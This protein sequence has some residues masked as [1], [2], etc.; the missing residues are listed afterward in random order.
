MVAISS[1]LQPASRSLRKPRSKASPIAGASASSEV[2]RKRVVMLVLVVYVLAIVEGSIRKW[3]LPQFSQ[4]IY[5]IRDP[6]LILAY[7]IATQHGLWPRNS[8]LF[9]VVVAMCGLGFVLVILQSA[10]GGASDTRF[11]LSVHGYRSYF[12][13][14]PLAFLVGAQFQRPDL[15]RFYRLTLWLAIPIAVLVFFQFFSPQGAAINVGSSSDENL[16]FR[17]LSTT[18]ERT[19]PM[20]TFASGAAQQQFVATAWAI[21]LALIISAGAR[22]RVSMA[23]LIPASAAVL[24]CIGLS[25]SRGTMLQCGLSVGFALMVGVIGRGG[26]LKGRAMVLT[27]GLLAA[28]VLLYPLVLPEGYA[29]FS[30]RW[31]AADKAESKT[32]ALG[33]FGRALY[34]LVDFVHLFDLVPLLGYG[35][36]YGSNA[37]ITLKAEV[38]GVMPG[39]LA[40]SDFTRH[41]VDLGPVLGMLYIAFRVTLTAWLTAMVLRVTRVVPDPM[42]LVLLSFVAVVISHGQVTGQGTI[43][44]YAWLFAGVL[45]AACN[46]AHN[47]A[48]HTAGAPAR[49]IAAA[50]SRAPGAARPERQKRSLA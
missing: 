45:I 6:F 5:F 44:V 43:N 29:A 23:L 47:T 31:N 32:F 28:A 42:P 30:E 25:G 22:R 10:I 14:V 13:Y 12:L 34:G 19:R 16:Q 40:E 20:G 18:A 33:V 9:K 15:T 1:P 8:L 38:D 4:Y 36:G 3:L 21:A 41:M 50:P 48:R 37:S 39:F 27:L 46:T 2:A 35:L 24:V 49:R 7:A 17:G 26:A 11:I